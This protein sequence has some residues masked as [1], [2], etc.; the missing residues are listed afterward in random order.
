MGS[1]PT[2]MRDAT[3]RLRQL[4]R[5]AALFRVA[6]LPVFAGLI[7]VDLCLA[8]LPTGTGLM[9]GALVSRLVSHPSDGHALTLLTLALGVLIFASQA[10]E[11]LHSALRVVGAQR[12]NAH[13][14]L[15]LGDLATRSDGIA[16]L[17]DPTV[18][19][20]LALAV[21]KGLPNWVAYTVGTGA[22]GQITITTRTVG[23]CAAAAVLAFY[24]WPLALCMLAVSLYVRSSTRRQWMKQHA[25][26]RSWA[27]E[28]RQE[29]YFIQVAAAPWAAKELRVF[30]LADW[31]IRRYRAVTG[32]RVD[33]TA[34]VRR[35]LLLRLRWHFV[36][37][38][39]ATGAGLA[40]LAVAAATGHIS[41]SQL[42]VFLGAFWGVL[43]VSRWDTEA[44]DVE[45]AGMP[46]LQAADRLAE[47]LAERPTTPL[48]AEHP[49]APRP[50]ERSTTPRLADHPTAPRPTERPTTPQDTPDPP[51]TAQSEPAP[52][53][54]VRFEAVDF[55]YEGTARSTLR[56]LDLEIR[57]GELLA[58]VGVNGAGKTTLTKL[59]AGL[60]QP[61]AG[62]VTA[63][64]VPL[65]AMDP[66]RWRRRITVVFQEFTRYEM[67]LRDNVVHGAPEFP[68]PERLLEDV[69]LQA[70]ITDLV[71][72]A[73][74]GW[75]TPLARGYTNGIDLSGGQWQRVAL[76]RALYAVACGAR[77][78]VLDE[79]TAHL[80]VRAELDV[81][82]RVM[83]HARGASV[84]L[85]S[86]RLSTVRRADRIAVLDGGRVVETGTHDELL[87]LDGPYAEMFRI[88]AA[89]FADV[90]VDARPDAADHKSDHDHDRADHDHDRDSTGH[91]R[92]SHST[93]STDNGD[94]DSDSHSSDRDSEVT[95]P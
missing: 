84:L 45:F 5:L 87:A 48:P 46:A 38:I 90:D 17:E 81:F 7:V 85:I 83:R 79:P 41:T 94:R 25:V 59:L 92:D 44:Y 42:A 4:W 23:A 12:V 58:L 75:D 69:A 56:G 30:G 36:L 35:R 62:A 16:G 37:L 20:D 68:E 32:D 43:A 72:R 1:R 55:R 78:L 39:I 26:V 73:P 77:L 66:A 51:A 82:T 9:T 3:T 50:A 53:P 24:S 31:A 91:D 10:F 86:H 49:T 47:R 14:R 2:A 34:V 65:A 15:S 33:G 61:T 64:G 57:P 27:P 22:A 74:A 80:D 89:R 71:E 95:A 76:A 21:T 29:D 67:S 13:Q 19:D 54:L 28:M 63:D 11:F 93:D 40:Q 88:Q 6:G 8:L 18:Q 52:P 60:Y 70:G